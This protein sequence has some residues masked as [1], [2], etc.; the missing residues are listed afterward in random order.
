MQNA[1]NSYIQCILYFCNS[2]CPCVT[3]QNKKWI[4][5][6]CIMIG[7]I[8]FFLPY[9][10]YSKWIASWYRYLKTRRSTY[11]SGINLNL[12]NNRYIYKSKSFRNIFDLFE[13]LHPRFFQYSSPML[14]VNWKSKTFIIN[15]DHY[16]PGD[17]VPSIIIFIWP[18]SPW[19][20]CHNFK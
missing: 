17:S 18:C 10:L 20:V 19:E 7:K 5:Q 3:I 11:F 4:L 2:Q 8:L 14:I 6:D 15:F 13:S 16:A 9:L 12:F 1:L